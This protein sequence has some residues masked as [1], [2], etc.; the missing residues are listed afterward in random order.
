VSTVDQPERAAEPEP[1]PLTGRVIAGKFE[2]EARLGS[3]GMGAVYRAR[4][5]ALEKTIALKVMH[6]DR[7]AGGL[8]A[9]RFH[10]EAKAASRLDHPNSIRIIDYGEEA[11]GLLYIAMEFVDGRDLFTVIEE[12]W[13]FSSARIVTILSQALAALAVAHDMGVLHRDVK[14]EN[15]MVLRSKSDEGT[16]V[17]AVKMCDFGIAKIMGVELTRP[18]SRPPAVGGKKERK[19]TTPGLL[20]GTPAYM[21]PEQGRGDP[22]DARSDLYSVGVILYELL[23]RR[24][25]FEANSPL[26][27][28]QKLVNDIPAAPSSIASVDPL[29]EAV[30]LKAMQKDPSKRYQKAREMRDALRATLLDPRGE[31]LEQSAKR[32]ARAHANTEI[33]LQSTSVSKRVTTGT[34]A[35]RAWS[36]LGAFVVLGGLTAFVATH[37][38][39]PPKPTTPDLTQAIAPTATR[40]ANT[41]AQPPETPEPH[42][43]PMSSP[44][45]LPI[46]VPPRPQ[47]ASRANGGASPANASPSNLNPNASQADASAAGAEAAKPPPPAPIAEPAAPIAAIVPPPP[48]KAPSVA[49]PPPIHVPPAFN[50]ATARVEMGRANNISATS[51]ARIQSALGPIG[52]ALTACYRDALPRLRAPVTTGATLH[53]ETDD[54]GHI[55]RA[56]VDGPLGAATGQCISAAVTTR[57]IAG[58]DTGN[59]SADVPLVFTPL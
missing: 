35:W 44:Q 41:L 15:I 19:L 45:A 33:D 46:S 53:I 26:G 14:P 59:A 48:T 9:D 27:L 4:H 10:R 42:Q 8:F 31:A 25:P 43:P 55:T 32:L 28:I 16:D 49:P 7:A 20:L 29:L 58:V 34:H 24:L 38:F 40:A 30:C 57:T 11:D 13:P 54:V 51:A 17:D 21:S 22:L 1:D 3:G 36:A 37:R 23:T 2:I 56:R 50:L 18:S 47:N 6:R 39:R 5:L 12:D 52:P